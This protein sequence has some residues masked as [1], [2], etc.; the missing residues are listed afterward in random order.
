MGL[1]CVIS[2]DFGAI[3]CVILYGFVC[4]GEGSVYCCVTFAIEV[5]SCDCVTSFGF[6]EISCN[7]MWFY[8]LSW[9]TSRNPAVL[10]SH[11]NAVSILYVFG[12][13]VIVQ[14]TIHT[15]LSLIHI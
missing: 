13:Y 6:V 12:S 10:R 11:C 8:V 4:F 14:K 7:F 2:C 3:S 9:A 1:F 5:I 15:V